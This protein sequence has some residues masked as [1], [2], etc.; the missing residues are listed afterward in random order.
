MLRAS[1][2]ARTAQIDPGRDGELARRV[3]H[4]VAAWSAKPRHRATRERRGAHAIEF[5]SRASTDEVGSSRRRAHTTGGREA[6]EA[7]G[8]TL[9]HSSR[10]SVEPVQGSKRCARA[11]RTT[12][13]RL[14]ANRFREVHALCEALRASLGSRCVQGM[15]NRHVSGIQDLTSL[16]N[17]VRCR[18]ST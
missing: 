18:L 17:G 4:D 3:S 12:T 9:A 8:N 2:R 6:A 14:G 10:S 11:R 13:E 5:K 7:Q 1:A 16:S 15:G